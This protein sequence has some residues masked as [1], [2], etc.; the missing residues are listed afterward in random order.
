MTAAASQVSRVAQVILDSPLPQLDHPFDYLVPDRLREEAAIGQ[1][2]TVPLRA[3]ARRS[4][5]WIVGFSD[6]SDFAG[7]LAEIES[8]ISPVAQL[9]PELYALARTVADRQAGSVVD[10]IRLAIP[11][12]YVRAEKEYFATRETTLTSGT[13]TNAPAGTR[14][15]LLIRSGVISVADQVWAP[16]WTA[17]FASKVSEVIAAGNSAILTVPDFRDVNILESA[18]IAAG[19][20]DRIVRTDASLAAA[21]RWTN[22][23]RILHEDSVV[24]IG[25]RSSVYAPVRNLGLIALWDATDESMTEPLAPYAH[26]RDV[27]LIRQAETACDLIIAA[28]ITSVESARLEKLGYLEQQLVE[29]EIPKIIATDRHS[30]KDDDERSARIPP[31]AI[32]AARAAITAGPVLIQVAKPGYASTLR[33]ASCRERALC[34]HCHGPLALKTKNGIPTCRWCARLVP[35]WSC[36]KCHSHTLAAGS[37]GSEKTAEELARAFPGVRVVFSDSEKRLTQL[38]GEPALV[39]ATSG[40]EPIV[41]GGYRAVLILDGESARTREDLDTDISALRTWMNAVALAA[42]G[43]PVYIAGTGEVLGAVVESGDFG[44]FARQTLNE[45]E[46]LGLPPATRVAI[47]T[48]SREAIAGVEKALDEIP[49]RSI[50][51]P[52]PISDEGYR[53]I[54]AFDYKDGATV[55][56]SLRALVLKTALTNRKPAGASNARARVLRLNVRIDDFALRGIG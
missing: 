33:C 14:T 5:A 6:T 46:A 20:S 29:S 26:P 23:L 12:R 18:L 2:V 47:V 39:I 56:T 7:N 45:R 40:T 17:A 48:G 55:A 9:T 36:T 13:S 24:V 15:S 22:Y 42:P 28:H 3:G 52:V 43:A 31:A 25:N 38:N 11:P 1:K 4:D 27:A 16:A 44:S 35:A 50:L 32:V 49:H 54:I 53:L 37:P 34:A 19:L 10:V 51:G 41:E 30:Q 8:I 21:T